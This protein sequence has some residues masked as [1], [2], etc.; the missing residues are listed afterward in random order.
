MAYTLVEILLKNGFDK[1][2]AELWQHN[3]D[4]ALGYLDSA[5]NKLSHEWDKSIGIPV[6]ERAYEK[7][8]KSKNMTVSVVPEE[9]DITTELYHFINNERDGLNIDD[10]ARNIEPHCEEPVHSDK[11]KGKYSKNIDLCFRCGRRVLVFE[12]K[13]LISKKDIKAYFGEEGIGCFTTDDSPY[14][15]EPVGSMVGYVL[16]NDLKFWTTSA[17]DETETT[18]NND[19]VLS[20]SFHMLGYSWELRKAENSPILIIHLALDFTQYVDHKRYTLEELKELITN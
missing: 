19:L 12:A 9:P 1:Q 14:C 17:N 8:K 7:I 6:K 3:V 11:R 10:P 13:R 15:T 16:A 5:Y 18:I 20:I 2:E 4:V